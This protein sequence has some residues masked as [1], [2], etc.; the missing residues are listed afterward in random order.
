MVLF[1]SSLQSE[2]GARVRNDKKNI[3][4][5]VVNAFLK[6]VR[7]NYS[8]DDANARNVVQAVTHLI[9]TL[10]YNNQLITAIVEQATQREY[11][12]QFLASYAPSWIQQSKIK[13]K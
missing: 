6:Y 7:E 2:K 8:E 5:N 12:K 11:F 10:K 9:E 4:K 13:T 1:K 3:A